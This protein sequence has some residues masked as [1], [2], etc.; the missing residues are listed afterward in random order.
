MKMSKVRVISNHQAA[1]LLKISAA[2]CG[3][4][5]AYA[6]KSNGSACIFPMV[7]HEFDP[8]K[9]DMDIKSGS[10]K[11]NG[12]FGLKLVSWFGENAERSLPALFGTNLIM[13]L[14]T[15][16]PKALLNGT[17]ITHMRTG[18]AGAIG[19]K[20]LS[21]PD[22]TTLLMIGTGELAPYEIAAAL[23]A[24]EGIQTVFVVNPHHSSGMDA[25]FDQIRLEV[26]NLMQKESRKGPY[27]LVLSENL[28]SAVQKADIII[29]ATPARDGFLKKEWIRPGTHISC[30]GAD[31]QGKNE[32]DAEACKNAK[33]FADDIA[34]SIQVGELQTA[35]AKGYCNS[36]DIIELGQVI[37]GNAPGRT[38]EQ[39][40]TIFDSTGIALQDLIVSAE[41]LKAAEKAG[42]GTICD[43]D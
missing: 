42:I 10:S 23:T 17:Y 13:D 35:A 11:K 27:Q 37:N 25:R 19:A 16:A 8:G 39:E 24:M 36:S 40:I 5:Q 15:G 21:R 4:E 29:T 38:S 30:I 31:M 20:Y 2:I 33:L 7:F 3:V 22:S 1:S 18:A 12:I 32:V 43:L 6:Q 34:Q 14:E 41:V 26:E 9:A 28:E